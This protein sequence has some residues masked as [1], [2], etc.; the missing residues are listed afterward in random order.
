VSSAGASD[1]T[2]AMD[3]IMRFKKEPFQRI[4]VSLNM[5]GT[6]FDCADVVNLVMARFTKSTMLVSANAR[7][8][9]PRSSAKLSESSLSP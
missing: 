5:L 9:R 7:A 2:N 8:S 4:L 6:R 1:T 3:K